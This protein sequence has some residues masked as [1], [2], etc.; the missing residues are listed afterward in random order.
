MQ[1]ENHII[2]IPKLF[3]NN[4][5]GQ[6]FYENYNETISKIEELGYAKTISSSE[7]I[8]EL[9][10]FFRSVQKINIYREYF[11]KVTIKWEETGDCKSAIKVYEIMAL[12]FPD[13][14]KIYYKLGEANFKL[15][16]YKKALLNYQECSKFVPEN[17]KLKEKIETVKE[18]IK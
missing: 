12:F 16:L 8:S 4:K 11:D 18:L 13:D 7:N 2:E 9:V 6:K 1:K 3:P 14:Y 17:E 15:K 5:K 10:K